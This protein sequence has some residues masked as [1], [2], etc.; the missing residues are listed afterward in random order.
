[1]NQNDFLAW[2][3]SLHHML[4]NHACV[5]AVMLAGVGGRTSQGTRAGRP[6][7]WSPAWLNTDSDKGCQPTGQAD[8]LLT[9]RCGLNAA[10]TEHVAAH[11]HGAYGTAAHGAQ[12]CVCV[13]SLHHYVLMLLLIITIFNIHFYKWLRQ[14]FPVPSS[15]NVTSCCSQT[16]QLT[17][18]MRLHLQHLQHSIEEQ[19]SQLS[20]LKAT[21][22]RNDQHIQ[23]LLTS[24]NGPAL[25]L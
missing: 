1:M 5:T 9:G 15:F 20:I 23:C 7:D 17:E 12:V 11:K 21:V 22:L 24:K 14:H 18:P 13:C 6:W 19:L 10:R 16:Q 2:Q 4:L 8:G 25:N 3:L